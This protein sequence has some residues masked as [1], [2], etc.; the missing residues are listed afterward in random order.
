MQLMKKHVIIVAGGTGKRMRSEKPKQFMLL[1][2]LPVLMHT[3]NA[4]YAFD[5]SIEIVVVL[6]R[7]HLQEWKMLC[8][9]FNYNIS[10]QVVEGGPTRFHSVK[11]GLDKIPDIDGYVAVHDGVRPFIDEDTIARCYRDAA[12]HGSAIPVIPPNDSLRII[13]VDS[14]KII[15][16]NRV[17]IIQ[18]PQVFNLNILRLAYKQ[19]FNE[20]FTDDASVVEAAGYKIFLTEGHRGNIK[21][22]HPE[23][24]IFASAWLKK[25]DTSAN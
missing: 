24:W 22:T 7:M 10:H 21:I 20:S 3:L 12:I 9:K 23:D 25:D 8:K 17:R 1:N 16:R 13:E 2:H 4:F 19:S 6:P 18:T 14:S 15:D 11:N 5:E